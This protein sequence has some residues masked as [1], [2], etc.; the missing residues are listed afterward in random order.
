M[1]E[2]LLPYYEKQLQEFGQQSRE[3]A[4]KYPKIAQRLALNQ[5]H[6][7][8]PHIE[9]LIQA[10]SLI[11]ARI[12]KKLNDSY[13]IFTRSIFEIMF[14]QYLK[15]F[16]ACSI[17][18]FEDTN[19]IKSLKEVHVVAKNT[20]LKARSI[21]GVQCEYRTV[22]SVTLLPIHLKEVNFKTHPSAY[23]HL[24]RN[25]TLILKFEIFNQQ[26][27]LLSQ[28]KLPLYLDA[29]SN[30]PLQLLDTIFKSD[31]Q[32]SFKYRAYETNIS[33]PFEVMGFAEEDS[34]L[35]VDQHTHQAYRLLTEYF[36]F[37]EKFNF[38]NINLDF[39]KAVTEAP[40]E[41]ELKIHFK[42]NLNDQAA[43][44]NY[45]ELNSANFKLFATP[46]V[47]LFEKQAEPQK[48]DH[49]RLEYPLISDVH[50]PEYFQVYGVTEMHLL[51]ETSDKKQLYFPVLPFF[52][53]SHYHQNDQQFFYQ[54]SPTADQ[55]NPI[56]FKYS[57][58]SKHLKPG[59]FTSDF[60]STRLLCTNRDLPFESYDQ[61][62][63]SLSLNENHLV[64]KARLL[65]RP[66]LPYR[67]QQ[68][69]LEQWRI[70]SHLSLNSLSLIKGDVVSHLKELLELY[71]L[72]QSK[73]NQLI[74]NS[75]Q[76][77]QFSL[78]QKLMS[79]QPFPLFI[80]GI[81]AEIQLDSQ[82]FR[83]ASVYI[84]AQILNHIF[85]LKVQMNSYVEMTVL[86]SESKQELYQCIQNVGGK[87]LL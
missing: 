15:T 31:T 30:F 39:L 70:I 71:N 51:R 50:H 20:V 57:I 7:D 42:A 12:D 65:K 54:I 85:N 38:L 46:V 6:I 47:N 32:F 1:I 27:Q 17:V 37:P 86:D 87:K 26:H 13:E 69:Q 62:Q 3:F 16:P 61:G 2:D 21:R 8:D 52:A 24:N 33:N 29:I 4:N 5:E 53:M 19:K 48:I 40:T 18:S 28:H 45:A 78:G 41:F 9:R 59:A 76:S 58:I 63:N 44:H 10:F 22:N 23:I 55:N 64:R 84:F 60:I 79:H 14:P 73:E 74:I 56:D 35:P 75:I 49:R 11:S 77:I 25:A 34:L 83:G 82:V 36:C 66:N 43:I 80:R 81:K 72:P 67:F 68:K